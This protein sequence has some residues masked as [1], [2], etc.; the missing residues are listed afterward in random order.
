MTTTSMGSP[1]FPSLRGLIDHGSPNEDWSLLDEILFETSQR[2]ERDEEQQEIATTPVLVALPTLTSLG[3]GCG[4]NRIRSTVGPL[5][6]DIETETVKEGIK[7]FLY[8]DSLVEAEIGYQDKVVE[9]DDSNIGCEDASSDGNQSDA[10][11]AAEMDDSGISL[12]FVDEVKGKAEGHLGIDDKGDDGENADEATRNEAPDS[13]TDGDD[14]DPVDSA[15]AISTSDTVEGGY[16]LN[17]NDNNNIDTVEPAKEKLGGPN[18]KPESFVTRYAS[19]QIEMET[20]KFLPSEGNENWKE[21][22]AD[23]GNA[24]LTGTSERGKDSRQ[25]IDEDNHA[26]R[27]EIGAGEDAELIATTSKILSS[28]EEQSHGNLLC[29]LCNWSA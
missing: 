8:L 27:V 12:A 5:A 14:V 19:A 16:Q 11:I 9:Q 17:R 7:Y 29:C 15:L 24:D 26:N 6:S 23:E 21:I 4:S 18:G 1:F 25:G 20:A 28:D 3:I 2:V 10:M 13:F 22:V